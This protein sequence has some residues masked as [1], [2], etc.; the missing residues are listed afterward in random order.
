MAHAQLTGKEQEED[1]L[2]SHRICASCLRVSRKIE[3]LVEVQPIKTAGSH[4]SLGNKP[5]MM[6]F[7]TRLHFRLEGVVLGRDWILRSLT[8]CNAVPACVLVWKPASHIWWNVWLVSMFL[9]SGHATA[10]D[11]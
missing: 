8:A 3:L 10:N 11:Y 5:R 7:V 1:E 6:S 2:C 9:T 4:V